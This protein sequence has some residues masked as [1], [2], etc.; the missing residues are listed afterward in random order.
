MAPIAT[1]EVIARISFRETTPVPS[2]ALL[3][4]FGADEDEEVSA[5]SRTGALT[6]K[7]SSSSSGGLVAAL[8]LSRQNSTDDEEASQRAPR[9]PPGYRGSPMTSADPRHASTLPNP[10][11]ESGRSLS[12][13]ALME[14]QQML[15]QRPRDLKGLLE[16]LGLSKYLTVF[17]EQDVDLQV[18]LSLTDNDL[19]EV[20]IK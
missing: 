2:L 6:I 20:G 15:A 8:G 12:A 14:Q 13:T 10:S 3:A 16:Q 9:P 4:E 19:K 5:F 17:E 11:S 18:F 1:P 7:S